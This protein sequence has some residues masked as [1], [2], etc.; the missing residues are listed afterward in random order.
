MGL[1]A[2]VLLIL[3]A[4]TMIATMVNL[5]EKVDQLEERLER[6]ET[7]EGGGR[8]TVL[9]GRSGASASFR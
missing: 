7:G 6:F 1:E 5:Y 3:F 4:V 9:E 8:R 2:V